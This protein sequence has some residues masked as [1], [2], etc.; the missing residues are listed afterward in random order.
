MSRTQTALIRQNVFSEWQGPSGGAF[1]IAVLYLVAGALWILFSDEAAAALTHDPAVLVQ[2]SLYKGWGYIFFT[3][4]ALFVVIQRHI[5]A[6]QKSQTQL[7][8]FIEQAPLSIAMFD[9]DMNYLA[10]SR[11]WLDEYGRGYPDLVGRN[12]YVVNPDL[13]DEWK[14]AHQDGLAGIAIQNDEDSWILADGSQQWLRWAISPWIDDHGKVGGIIL[15]AIDITDRKRAEKALRHTMEDLKR[16]NIE[17]EQFAYVASH[18]L[19]EP[20][21]ALTGMVQLLQRR[22]QGQLDARADE[23]IAH[24]VDAARRMQTLINDLLSYSRVGTRGRAFEMIDMHVVLQ[25]TLANLSVLI[26]ENA[27]VITHDPLPTVRVDAMQLGQ[28]FQNLIGNAIKFRSDEPPIIHIG[29]ERLPD[30]WR[31]SVRDNGI[32]IDPQYFERIF[33]VFQRL[34]TRR[35]YPGTGIGLAICKKIVERH[36]GTIGVESQPGRGSTF[37]F[38]IPH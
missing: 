17:L 25:S 27:A 24:T 3:A 7:R 18:D 30:S 36:G 2:I 29:A 10:T 26:Q 37:Y 1:R 16:S 28:I 15:S 4:L 21:R 33:A 38:T 14:E 8:W 19:Q 23:Y 20:L 9:R 6:L 22:Y 11:R 13:P 31:F 35:E 34:H 32:G 5:G 12:H